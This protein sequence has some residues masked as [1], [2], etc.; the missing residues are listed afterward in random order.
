MDLKIELLMAVGNGVEEAVFQTLVL[1]QNMYS[2]R[3]HL[4]FLAAPGKGGDILCELV[5]ALCSIILVFIAVKTK[6]GAN[7]PRE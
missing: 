3:E 1:W 6:I 2:L 4:Q 7:A 5:T